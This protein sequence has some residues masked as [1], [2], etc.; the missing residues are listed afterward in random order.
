[1]ARGGKEG[2][3]FMADVVYRNLGARSPR[4]RFGPGRGFDNAVVSLGGGRVMILTVDPVSA[5]Q[6]LGM[7]LSAWLS[8]HLIASDYTASGAD[9][10]LAT[11][12]YN[13]PGEMT[14]GERE[15]YLR[16]V[17]DECRILGVSII[18]GH[19]GTY[20]G[21]G[22]TVIGVGSM[23]GFS[24]EG[25]YVTPSMARAGDSI[26]MTK[27]A[28]IEAT[29]TLA[30]S[31]PN[32]VDSRV[33]RTRAT[34]ARRMTSLCSTVLD[35]LAARRVG[36]GGDGVSSMH[37]AT[38]GGVLGGLEEMAAASSK[39]F[40]VEVDEIPVSPEAVGVCSSFGVDPVRTMGEG[41][42][43]ITCNRTRVLEL[44]RLMRRA[45]IPVARIGE[46]RDGSGL[47]LRQGH[48]VRRYSPGPDKYWKAYAAA[49][50]R[51]LA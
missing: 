15:E 37:D 35:A 34:R 2:P 13:F 10:E 3:K 5:I 21:G 11:F 27:T 43:L 32:F 7:K 36:L 31:F 22:Y 29:A 26:L 19:T 42:L 45:S 46:V 17:G 6:T 23:L 28:A 39:S 38:E 33:G 20:P 40:V 44:K 47:L 14:S 30:R 48:V 9:P 25:R 18:G 1:M 8:V 12:S 24:S 50:I 49:V 51:K 16:S 4:I 41:S